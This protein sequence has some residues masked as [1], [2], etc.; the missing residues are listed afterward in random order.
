MH[1]TATSQ[2]WEVADVPG[3]TDKQ[4]MQNALYKP[5]NEANNNNN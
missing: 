5:E 3:E 1:N 4:H 2:A